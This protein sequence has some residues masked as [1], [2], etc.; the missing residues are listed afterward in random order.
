[1]SMYGAAQPGAEEPPP[2]PNPSGP[3]GAA[4]PVLG[5]LPPPPP[6]APA[7]PTD[8]PAKANQ[9][10]QQDVEKD[11]PASYDTTRLPGSGTVLGARSAQATAAAAGTGLA[12]PGTSSNP[13]PGPDPDHGSPAGRVYSADMLAAATGRRALRQRPFP[14]LHI[15]THTVN[16]AALAE[17]SP[18]GEGTGLLLGYDRSAKPVMI[19][20]FRPEATRITLVG[21]L[22][23]AQIA[24]FR[25]L[26]LGA[27]VVILTNRPELWQRFGER[28]T[29][30]SDRVAVVPAAR[31]VTVTATPLIPALLL[32]DEG[33]LSASVRP[34][35]APWQT[36]LT[37]LTQL[38][39]YGFPAIQESN[40]VAM[41][42]LSKEEAYTAASVLKLPADT[43]ALLPQ[44]HNDMLALLGG[45]AD[46]YVWLCPTS[47]EQREFGQAYR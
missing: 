46:R 34:N 7:E 22:W 21:G 37:V 33:L 9:D 32:Y 26:A 39:A 24:A 41:Q 2:A 23:A 28:A 19:R 30:R 45:E 12:V 44:M 38:T 42:R 11:T 10:D 1:M 25:A 35:L 15:G 3:P 29:G 36:Q 6:P 4:S 43:A 18:S 16:E 20:M 40:L 5:S 8:A 47:T 13:P 27:R 17:L 31:P 14:K